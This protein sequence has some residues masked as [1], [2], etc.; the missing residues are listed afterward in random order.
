MNKKILIIGILATVL[1]VLAPLSPVVGTSIVK[2]DAEKGSPLF[3][4]RAQRS[5]SKE[6]AKNIISNYLGKG[7]QLNILLPERATTQIWVN[8]ALKIVDKE[9]ALFNNLIEKLDK[10]PYAA[11]MLN[12]YDI[13]TQDIKNYIEMI[14]D[15]P[16]VLADE[17]ENIQ[18]PIDNTPLPLGLS[19][20]LIECLVTAIVVSIVATVV[21]LVV[22]L[23]TLRIFTCM[24]VN[25]CANDIAQGIIDQM[26]QGLTES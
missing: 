13:S 20:T 3:A 5:L 7:E 18:A 8:R 21:T 22:L 10:T 14:K 12:K 2:P 1:I 15:N 6:N 26:T 11:R 19:T 17:I 16:S 23:F 24:N 4:V 25:N 9:P